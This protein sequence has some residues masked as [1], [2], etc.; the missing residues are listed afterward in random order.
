VT[1]AVAWFEVTP[2]PLAVATFVMLP[3]VTSAW[4]IVCVEVQVVEPPAPAGRNHTAR[5]CLLVVCDAERS[6]QRRLARVRDLVGVVITSPT[7]E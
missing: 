5:W 6:A 4:E 1:V 3:A 7:L 2:L